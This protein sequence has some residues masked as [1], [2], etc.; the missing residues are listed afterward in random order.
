[1]DIWQFKIRRLRKLLKDW[2]MNIEA[3]QK[4]HK[5]SLI[6]EYDCLDILSESQPLLLEEQERLKA[7]RSELNKIWAMEEI[8]A[9]Q[10]AREKDILEG[11]KNTA[12]FHAVANQRR[13]KKDC[14]TR[15]TYWSSS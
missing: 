11:D 13:R 3:A 14:F 4:K 15:G 8:K 9:R 6:A 10:R 12:Y 1:M 5:K 7:I 2:S